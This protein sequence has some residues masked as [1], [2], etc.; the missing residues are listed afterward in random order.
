MDSY[1]SKLYIRIFYHDKEA[2]KNIIRVEMKTIL[3]FSMKLLFHEP[4]SMM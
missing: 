3:V 4:V 1:G 2:Q